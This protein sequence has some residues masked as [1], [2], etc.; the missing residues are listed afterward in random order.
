MN[1]NYMDKGNASEIKPLEFEDDMDVFFVVCL[2]D[3]QIQYNN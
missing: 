1:I 2:R 3:I